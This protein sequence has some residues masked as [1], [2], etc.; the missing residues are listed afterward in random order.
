MRTSRTARGVTLALVI[1]ALNFAV[2]APVPAG[3]V[4]EL[5][6]GDLTLGFSAKGAS[7]VK[8]V[9]GGVDYAHGMSSFGDRIIQER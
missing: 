4:L 7:L 5:S 9:V 3:P 1:V 6:D 8:A 2:A